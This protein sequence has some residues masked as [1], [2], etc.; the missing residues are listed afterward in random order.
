MAIIGTKFWQS[1]GLTF[2]NQWDYF[3]FSRHLNIPN[4][5]ENI[6]LA[7]YVKKCGYCRCETE[8]EWR[9]QGN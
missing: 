9:K 6:G 5:E 4:A 1:M 2:G 8:R 7:Q 3:V